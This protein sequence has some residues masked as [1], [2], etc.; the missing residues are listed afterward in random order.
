MQDILA[1]EMIE[2]NDEHEEIS[3]QNKPSCFGRKLGCEACFHNCPVSDECYE[4]K[5]VQSTS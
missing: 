2:T 1:K 4:I 5:G 3:D